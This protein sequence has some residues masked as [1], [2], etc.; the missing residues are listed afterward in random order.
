MQIKVTV[1]VS[2]SLR[3]ALGSSKLSVELAENA[4]LADLLNHLRQHYPGL[5]QKLDGD[6]IHSHIPYS[7]FVNRKAVSLSQLSERRLRNGDRVHILVPVVG[8]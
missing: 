6:G 2:P 8:G 7:Y 3:D 1:K 4:S 5:G